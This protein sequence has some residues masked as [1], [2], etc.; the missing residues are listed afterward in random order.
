M[1]G[2]HGEVPTTANASLAEFIGKRQRRLCKPCAERQPR[3]S[4]PDDGSGGVVGRL[5]WKAVDLHYRRAAHFQ[6]SALSP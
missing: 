5:N 2:T 4:R 6:L 3:E 1:Q